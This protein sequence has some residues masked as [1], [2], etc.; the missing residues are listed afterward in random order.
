[1]KLKNKVII[2]DGPADDRSRLTSPL[3]LFKAIESSNMLGRRA[4]AYAYEFTAGPDL[5]AQTY[6]EMLTSATKL[7]DNIKQFIGQ[8]SGRAMVVT[9]W[10]YDYA[11]RLRASRSDTA[12][13]DIA[14]IDDKILTLFGLQDKLSGAERSKDVCLFLAGNGLEENMGEAVDYSFEYVRA[15]G[16]LNS[17]DGHKMLR[18]YNIKKED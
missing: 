13:T 14:G 3:R 2:I 4:G 18:L 9:N 6:D 17:M 7:V 15:S 16:Y 12:I 1:M 8:T 11:V 5:S 10:M